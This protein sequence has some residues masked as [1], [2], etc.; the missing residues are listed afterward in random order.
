MSQNGTWPLVFEGHVLTGDW[1][2]PPAGRMQGKANIFMQRSYINSDCLR[3]ML[4]GSL[5]TFTAFFGLVGAQAGW[6]Q[7]SAARATGALTVR[8]IAV[9]GAVARP[10]IEV[11]TSGPVSPATQA[12]TGPDRIVIDFPGALPAKT[13]RALSVHQGNL[14]GIRTGLFQAQPPITRV[15]LD[16][17]GPTDYQVTPVGNSIVIRL[18]KP[19]GPQNAVA[20]VAAPVRPAGAEI[21]RA[22]GNGMATLVPVATDGT[23][24]GSMSGT[25]AGTPPAPV[26][27]SAPVTPAAPRLEVTVRG[28]LLSIHTE[29][30]TLSEVLYEIHRQTGADIAIPAG[31]EQERVVVRLGPGPGKEVISALLN[32]SRF[33]YILVGSDQDRGG[34]SNLLLSLKTGG[35]SSGMFAHAAPDPG[36]QQ[37]GQPAAPDPGVEQTGIDPSLAQA[38]P[39]LETVPDEAPEPAANGAANGGQ[40]GVPQQQPIQPIA[41]GVQQ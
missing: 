12:V 36:S 18:G 30:A 16:V 26:A 2:A 15:V 28:N 11:K 23:M 38:E 6:A 21:R 14:R 37:F 5:M 41:D 31:A 17:D 33:N 24:A 20:T 13:L 40:P 19:V 7:T 29:G 8:S 35:G 32:G 4:L 39:E 1:A 27:L 25:M 3:W 9:G 22:A 10:E 34:F